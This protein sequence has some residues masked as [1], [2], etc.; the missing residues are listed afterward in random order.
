MKMRFLL[1]FVALAPSAFAKLPESYYRD[2]VASLMD[3]RT[4]V[5][6]S[7]GTWCDIVTRDLA[8][9]VDFAPNWAE[10]IGQ[11]LHYGAEFDRSP[12]IV[13]V[14]RNP[15]DERY[16]KRL[17]DSLAR[18]EIGIQIYVLF[19]R[20]GTLVLESQGLSYGF[21]A[22][23]FR[24]PKNNRGADEPFFKE[25]LVK[26]KSSSPLVSWWVVATILAGP[27]LILASR[28]TSKRSTP[29]QD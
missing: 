17:F 27:V 19:E 18:Y 8:I 6:T 21:V 11:S 16:V 15:G 20:R 5:R 9:E 7:S 10:S 26:P 14:L 2:H 3:G 28:L 25:D 12:G 24:T 13:L 1:V 22:P 23:E 4:E 29:E